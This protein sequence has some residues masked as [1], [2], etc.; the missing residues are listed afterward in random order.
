MG[1]LV[2]LHG[3]VAYCNGVAGTAVG[4]HNGRF[5]N[6]DFAIDHNKRVCGAEVNG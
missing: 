4:G 6:D 2:H 1:F 5:I 3:L